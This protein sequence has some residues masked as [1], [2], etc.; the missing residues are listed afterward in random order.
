[1]LCPRCRV[2]LKCVKTTGGIFFRCPQCD[3]RAVGMSL[4]RRVG[5]QKS[6]GELWQQARTGGGPT[7]AECPEC[8]QPMLEVLVPGTV[9]SLR[10]DVCTGCEFVWFDPNE[11]QQFPSPVTTGPKPLPEKVREAI[12]LQQVRQVAEEAERASYDDPGPEE[13]WPM[14]SRIVWPAD[15]GRGRRHEVLALADVRVGSMLVVVYAFTA[16]NLRLEFISKG[17]AV[18]KR[19][20]RRNHSRAHA[21]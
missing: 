13:T 15:R 7:R 9:P 20:A 4:R 3:G 6:V 1:M 19:W 5:S 11:F 12:A 8:H 17:Y 21:N 14:D 16:A 18:L 10:L 2:D